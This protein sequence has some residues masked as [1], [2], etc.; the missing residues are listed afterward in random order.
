MEFK[1]LKIDSLIPAEY[2]P[3]KKLKPGDSEFEKIKNSI[4]EFGYVDPVI[5]NKDLTVIGGHQRISVLKTLGVTEID[6]V[7][8]DVDNDYSYPSEEL[9]SKYY[10]VMNV[11]DIKYSKVSEYSDFAVSANTINKDKRLCKPLENAFDNYN[12]RIYLY[13][14]VTIAD[15]KHALNIDKFGSYENIYDETGK[16]TEKAYIYFDEK[17]EQNT[18][19]NIIS[20]S[21]L[22]SSKNL[23]AKVTPEKNKKI[24]DNDYIKIIIDDYAS[25]KALTNNKTGAL[26]VKSGFNYRSYYGT[27]DYVNLDYLLYRDYDEED[28][29]YDYFA[30]KTNFSAYSK[31]GVVYSIDAKHALPYGSDEMLDYGP[32]DISWAK[33]VSVGLDLASASVSFSFDVDGGPTIDTTYSASDDYCKWDIKKNPLSSAFLGNKLFSLGSSWASTGRFAGTDVSFRGEFYTGYMIPSPKYYTS[34]WE[35][36]QIRYQY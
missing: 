33:S 16:S 18:V 5:V 22:Q 26:I 28:S 3:R 25:M 21:N 13:G 10:D 12:S 1:K 2:N 17:Q 27:N 32:G 24:T 14:K 30:I 29:A 7:I 20:Y 15:F 31:T 19:E 6:C 36:V 9:S 11:K 4:N 35:T 23:L 8:V 34:P